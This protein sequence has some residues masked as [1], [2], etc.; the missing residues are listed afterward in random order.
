[1]KIKEKVKFEVW[2]RQKNANV[3]LVNMSL[4]QEAK[5]FPIEEVLNFP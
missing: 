3:S 2:E 5:A 1:M 4:C